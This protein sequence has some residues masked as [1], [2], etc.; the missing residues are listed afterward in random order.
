MIN[1]S[2]HREL[3][4]EREMAMI[5]RAE[6]SMV[7]AQARRRPG[8]GGGAGGRSLLARLLRRSP[9]L[10]HGPIAGAITIRHAFPDDA[11]AL[12]RLASLD[13]APLPAQPLLV[14]EVEGVAWAALSLANGALIADPF[15]RTGG[16]VEL[17][18]A[19]AAQLRASTDGSVRGARYAQM[20]VA[21][22]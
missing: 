18:H 12:N 2:L 3:M 7:A 17:L 10:D 15:R 6:A 8:A 1:P 5:R 4:A 13:S 9:R 19:R 11:A 16:L 21:R 14:A 22:L 20:S